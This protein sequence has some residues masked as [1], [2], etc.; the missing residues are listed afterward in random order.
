MSSQIRCWRQGRGQARSVRDVRT[1]CQKVIINRQAAVGPSHIPINH[2]ISSCRAGGLPLSHRRLSHQDFLSSRAAPYRA[3]YSAIKR[4]CTARP[5]T[6][7]SPADHEA[8][9]AAPGAQARRRNNYQSY[10]NRARTRH[11]IVA[12][13]R[14]TR[15]NHEGKNSFTSTN[16][17]FAFHPLPKFA[18]T[19]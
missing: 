16:A 19:L 8:W 6:H 9:N 12:S 10:L 13:L 14:S 2:A 17:Q 11:L 5:R 15:T 1:V 18:G 3:M 7:A 4:G